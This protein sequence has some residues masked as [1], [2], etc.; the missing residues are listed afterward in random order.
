MVGCS[1][2]TG[3]RCGNL[4]KWDNLYSLEGLNRVNPVI[5]W[6]CQPVKTCKKQRRLEEYVAAGQNPLIGSLWP[7]KYV[8]TASHD[9][10][11]CKTIISLC[12]S[13][14]KAIS[15]QG[16]LSGYSFSPQFVEVERLHSQNL[17]LV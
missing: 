7:I 4:R 13:V 10:K 14:S 11:Q 15:S 8:N 9:V 16:G 6:C 2:E 17:K 3:F 12:L 1:G 5:D